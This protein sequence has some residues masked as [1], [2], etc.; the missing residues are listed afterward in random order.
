MGIRVLSASEATASTLEQFGL[1]PEIAL[2]SEEAI[3]AALRGAG[4]FLCPTSPVRLRSRV[5]AS[6]SPLVEIDDA[7]VESTLDRI[8]AHGDLALRDRADSSQGRSELFLGVPAFVPRVS[9]R[10]LLLGVRPNGEDLVSETLHRRFAFDRY[11]RT[12]TREPGEPLEAE[13]S[14]EGLSCITEAAWL[15]APAATSAPDH[16]ALSLASL[17]AASPSGPIQG[18]RIIDP[19]SDVRFYKGR[20][21]QPKPIDGG[22]AVGRRPQA[23][24]ADLWCLVELSRGAPLRFVDLPL[25]GRG[26]GADVAWRLQAAIDAS[27]GHPQVIRVGDMDLDRTR[28]DIFSP[29]PSWLQRRWDAVARGSTRGAGALQSWAFLN[30]ELEEEVEF[31]QGYMWVEV[32]R[33]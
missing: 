27:L 18:L 29:I 6:L 22:Y 13:L 28:V 4:S 1:P 8:V 32:V 19:S 7:V 17:Q 26:L 11:V 20:W 10:F 2:N 21:R 9:G 33:R 23:F 3:A 30:A 5:S 15:R 16:I 25:D 24:G 14:A 12:L 31:A